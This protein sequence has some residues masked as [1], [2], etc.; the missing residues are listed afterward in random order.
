MCTSCELG[1]YPALA[2]DNEPKTL[3]ELAKATGADPTLLRTS[4]KVSNITA[5]PF[6]RD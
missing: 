3:A 1:L 4:L 6:N 2:A 5:A